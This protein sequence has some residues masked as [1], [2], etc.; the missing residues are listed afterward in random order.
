MALNAAVLAYFEYLLQVNISLIIL[1]KWQSIRLVDI[2]K[3]FLWM[4]LGPSAMFTFSDL[5]I[6]LMSLVR[7]FGRSNLFMEIIYLTV[8]LIS[9]WNASEESLNDN[10]KVLSD[11]KEQ[12]PLLLLFL[13]VREY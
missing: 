8:I 13:V 5:I 11:K 6:L 1:A 9:S 2:L 4:R 12:Y 10:G 7:V 3:N